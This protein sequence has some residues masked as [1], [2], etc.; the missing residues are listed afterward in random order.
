MI[1]Q[2]SAGGVIFKDNLVLIIRNYKPERSVDYWGFPK[3][4]IEP[5][6]SE[7]EAAIREVKEETG[8]EVKVIQKIADKEYSAGFNDNNEE[9]RKKVSYYVM[10]Y[11]SGEVK[12]QEDELSEAAW[13]SLEE[14]TQKLTFD[15]DKQILQKA[16]ELKKLL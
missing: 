8:V 15:N 16:K 2:Y 13:I 7:T 3:G 14:A 1:H 10:E 9:I 4:H 6:E 11:I 5:G 12:P